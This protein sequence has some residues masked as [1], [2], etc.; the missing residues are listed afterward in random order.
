MVTFSRRSG[1]GRV[2]SPL[3]GHACDTDAWPLAVVTVASGSLS[4]LGL[5]IGEGRCSSARVDARACVCP[6]CVSKTCPGA[7]HASCDFT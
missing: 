3:M 5:F 4:R 2:V 6:I 7:K 1:I